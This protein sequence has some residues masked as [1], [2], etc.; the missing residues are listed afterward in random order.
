MHAPIELESKIKRTDTR[1]GRMSYYV[2]D[3]FIGHALEKYGEYSEA[4]P[5]LWSKFLKSSDYV[6][7]VG[8]NIGCF[9]LALHNMVH[10]GGLV[11]AFEPQPENFALLKRNTEHFDDIVIE[12][13]ALGE[14]SDVIKI[15]PLSSLGHTNYGGFELRDSGGPEDFNI[16]I[17]PLDE[18]YEADR[19]AFIKIDV[20]GMETKV[21]LG[22]AKL[23]N[24]FRPVMYVENDRPENAEK[25]VQILLD[26]GYKLYGHKP[27]LYSSNNY[28]GVPLDEQN[29][30]SINLLC[31]PKERDQEFVDSG[32]TEGLWS[33]D[34]ETK[35]PSVSSNKG[36]ACVVRLGGIGDNLIAASTLRPLKKQGYMVEVITKEP[37]A[38]VFENNPFID[39]LTIKTDRELPQNDQVA[40]QKY[41]WS[42]SC[43]FAKFVNLSHS[44]EV[45]MAR[46]QAETAFWWAPEFRRKMCGHSYLEAA[47]DVVGVPHDFGPLF[48]P[49]DDEKADIDSFKHRH[50]L[51]KKPL[52]GWV[53]S[54]TR[55]DK[56]YPFGGMAIARMLSEL[57]ANVIMMSSPASARPIDAQHA[58]QIM[59]HVKMTNSSASG[60]YEVRDV[61]GTHS[62]SIRRM[63]TLAQQCDLVIGPD[64]GIMWAVALEETPKIVLHSHASVENITKHWH[65]TISLHADQ[66]KVPCSPCHL[67]H[68]T[69]DTCR[70]MQIK[71][72]MKPSVEDIGSACIRDISVQ[73]LMAAAKTALNKDHFMLL[74]RTFPNNVTLR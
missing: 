45:L 62:W 57:D 3:R 6:I 55:V 40:W 12:H 20:E 54:G 31:I 47:H 21:L 73:C 34:R 68:D 51:D 32:I 16:R 38:C 36:W 33:F 19:L 22:A 42:R 66:R 69:I 27:L 30:I 50:G 72:G 59:N 41:W 65:S 48:F 53:V 52:I 4:E 17:A 43:E 44:V 63:L 2:D 49:T 13:L 24:Q 8:A 71:A 67:L 46:F 7:D 29:I 15:G 23:I 11:F 61:P 5:E 60:L 10:P 25:L 64:S 74:Q 39:K 14:K 56:L 9:T 26:F 58:E 28:K 37:Q 70:E 18:Y 1:Y 35:V